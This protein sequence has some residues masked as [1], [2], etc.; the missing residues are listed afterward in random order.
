MCAWVLRWILWQPGD[1]ELGF[2]ASRIRRCA[3][4]GFFYVVNL[5]M[6]NSLKWVLFNKVSGQITSNALWK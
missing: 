3:A 1:F 6:D 4:L 2:F 5:E